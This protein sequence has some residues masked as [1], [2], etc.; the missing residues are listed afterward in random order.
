MGNVE[1]GNGRASTYRKHVKNPEPNR[2]PYRVRVVP[3]SEMAMNDSEKK[4]YDE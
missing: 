1:M 4:I 3:N 2:Y